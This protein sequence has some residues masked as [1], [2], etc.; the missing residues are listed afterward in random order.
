M[1]NLGEW[2]S[3]VQDAKAIAKN[4]SRPLVVVSCN[5]KTCNYCKEAEAKV[6]QNQA[7]K[8][9]VKSH[10]IP[11]FLADQKTKETLAIRNAL[12]KEYNNAYFPTVMIFRVLDSADLTTNDLNY[13]PIKEIVA[14]FMSK[15]GMGAKP[16]QAANPNVELIGKFV[17]RK[18]AKTN[19]GK[20][21]EIT[22]EEFV[23]ALES[24]YSQTHPEWLKN[25]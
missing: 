12:Q 15:F 11:Q 14:S 20:V 22:P 16:R 3:S 21:A 24:F 10:G 18:G 5:S 23:K 4:N 2:N 17:F 9:Y 7:W 6:F 1:S 25:V 19:A 8:N 13:R